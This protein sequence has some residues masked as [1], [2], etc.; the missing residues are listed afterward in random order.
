MYLRI[1]GDISVTNFTKKDNAFRLI[2]I[3]VG[4]SV[5]NHRG[6]KKKI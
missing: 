5:F 3:S 2:S 4:V 6:I 1:K